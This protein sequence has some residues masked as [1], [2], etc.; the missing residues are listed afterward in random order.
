MMK[1]HGRTT[2][3]NTC[4]THA[5][6]AEPLEVPERIIFF[7]SCLKF[8]RWVPVSLAPNQQAETLVR[9]T[10]ERFGAV[11]AV[12]VSGARACG[13][14]TAARGL[15]SQGPWASLSA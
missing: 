5:T 9:A 8:S 11:G 12:G 3:R 10:C 1:R 6:R 15:C 7:A 2:F 13:T 14:H 4:H